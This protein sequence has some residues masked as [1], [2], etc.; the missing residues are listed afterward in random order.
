[1]RSLICLIFPLMIVYGKRMNA[2]VI[3]AFSL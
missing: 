2:S 3:L 1:M